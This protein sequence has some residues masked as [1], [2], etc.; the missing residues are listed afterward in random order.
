MTAGTPQGGILSPLLANIYLNY[1]DKVWEERCRQIGVLVR[2]ADDLVIL[3]R[4]E[5]D[6]QEALWRLGIVMERLGLKLHPVKTRLVNLKEGREGFDFLGFHMRKVRSWRYGRYY[7]QRW[8]GRKAMKAIREK[9]RAIV[10]P[11]SRLPRDLREVIDE[12]NPV[13]R[14]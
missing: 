6:A 10:G 11:R 2:Y 1:L 12:V 5:K 4:S 7:L 3:C 14:G 9:V 13:L 8:P